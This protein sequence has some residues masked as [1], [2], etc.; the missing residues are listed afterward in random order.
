MHS[1]PSS[2]A[3][4]PRVYVQW[5]GDG[6]DSD[7]RGVVTVIALDAC[8]PPSDAP[9]IIQCFSSLS[10]INICACIHVSMYIIVAE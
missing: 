6:R 2:L 4:A 10:E 9:D 1:P 7:V 3:L 5:E 8:L